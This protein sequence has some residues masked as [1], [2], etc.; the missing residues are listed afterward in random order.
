M[1]RKKAFSSKQK[2]AQLAEKRARKQAASGHDDDDDE[3]V[4]GDHDADPSQLPIPQVPRPT[5]ISTNPRLLPS[6]HDDSIESGDV[7]DVEE[8]SSSSFPRRP[9]PGTRHHQL[10]HHLPHKRREDEDEGHP[11]HGEGHET[12]GADTDDVSM[13]DGVVGE[14]GLNERSERDVKAHRLQSVFAKLSPK[15]MEERKRESQ[16]P[17]TRLPEEALEIG[18]ENLYPG[19]STIDFPKRPP[20]TRGESK[21]ELE[22]RETKYFNEW[23]QKTYAQW[24][25]DKLSYFEHNLEVWRQLWR[26]V[27]ISDIILFV[28]DSRHPILHFPPTLYDYVV[29]KMKKKLVLV[30]NKIDLVDPIT[31]SA[32]RDYFHSLYPSLHVA[33]F[34]IYPPEVHLPTPSADA[35]SST[36]ATRLKAPTTSSRLQRFSRSVGVTAVLEACRDVEVVKG[37][38]KVDWEHMIA[39]EAARRKRMEEDEVGGVPVVEEREKRRRRRAKKGEDEEEEADADD[40]ED[41]ENTDKE[42]D[43]EDGPDGAMREGEGEIGVM[44][45][46]KDLITIGLILSGMYKIAQVQEP[47]SS[48][49]YLAERVPIERVLKLTPPDGDKKDANHNWTAWEI[50]EAYA[51]AKGFLTPRVGRPDVYRAA[52]LILRMA[53]DGRLL[54]GFKPPGFFASLKAR[55][56]SLVAGSS[57]RGRLG[58]LQVNNKPDADREGAADE[59]EEGDEDDDR[60]RTA[61]F[62]AFAMLSVDD[63]ED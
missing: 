28:V 13:R 55:I 15:E 49:Q 51:I 9:L 32:W 44:D 53:N 31:L 35:S 6:A 36:A 17:F 10:H 2:K 43:D 11:G 20:W 42:E 37:G 48:V 1:H 40:D 39:E 24:P 33:H 46:R 16:L 22:E 21:E 61:S 62:N 4:A 19:N 26:V 30:F 56:E 34:S 27:E 41:E 57:A 29:N 54:M 45:P 5:R 60:G 3:N 59:E 7:G 18:F 47:Y 14:R 58:I 23:M 8:S 25:A 63:E 52:N 38:V 50:C 12:E